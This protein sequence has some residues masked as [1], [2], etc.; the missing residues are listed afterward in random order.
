MS[1]SIVHWEKYNRG[2]RTKFP[3]TVHLLFFREDRVL[4][5]RRFNTGYADGQYSVPAG[6]LDGGETVLAAAAR[7]AQEET[8]LQLDMDDI[9]FSSVVHRI[10]EEERV[11]FFV[12]VRRWQGE[13]ANTEPDKCDE[14]RWVNVHELPGN[15]IP[16]VKK[17]IQNHQAGIVFQEFGWQISDP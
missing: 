17:A 13:P 7:E 1:C 10:E 15:T 3:V 11:D 2:M 16:Y 14:L 12:H 9:I 8:G 5:L 4:L 6:H